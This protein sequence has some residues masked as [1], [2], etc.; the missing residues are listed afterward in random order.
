[1]FFG[2]F[3]N[4]MTSG[5]KIIQKIYF[6]SGSD[7][8]RTK[9]TSSPTDKDK[10]KVRRQVSDFMDGPFFRSDI[11]QLYILTLVLCA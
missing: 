9:T 5:L 4:R 8:D 3:H 10:A 7:E 2:I 1:M 11:Y 6:L